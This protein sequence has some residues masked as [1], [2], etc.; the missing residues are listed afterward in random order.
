[1]VKNLSRISVLLISQIGKAKSFP[2]PVF[3]MELLQTDQL[4]S[5]SMVSLLILCAFSHPLHYA[6]SKD[7][8]VWSSR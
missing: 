5:Q 3:W 4:S 7:Y 1:M 6:F 2:G 8:L